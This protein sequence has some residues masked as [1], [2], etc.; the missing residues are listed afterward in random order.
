MFLL[1]KKTAEPTWDRLFGWLGCAIFLGGQSK[2]TMNRGLKDECLRYINITFKNED[3]IINNRP[4][5]G[6]WY[7]WQTFII[8]SLASQVSQE[9]GFSSKGSF[10]Q[11]TLLYFEWSPPWHAGW[12]FSGEGCHLAPEVKQSGSEFKTVWDANLLKNYALFQHQDLRLCSERDM[13]IPYLKGAARHA[14]NF[15]TKAQHTKLAM[16]K[17]ASQTS[18][19]LCPP[20]LRVLPT[21]FWHS[22]WHIFEHSFWHPFS[23]I[24]SELP[25]DMSSD[26]LSDISSDTETDQFSDTWLQVQR[27]HCC[28]RIAVDFRRGTLLSQARGWG[29]ARNTGLTGSR[30]RSGTPHCTGRLAVEVQHTTL[31]WQDRGW[32]A[33]RNT[34]LTG[35]RLRSGAPHCTGRIAVEVRH[36]TLASQDRGWGP[37]RHTALAGSRLRSGTPHWTHSIAVEVRRITLKSHGR[38]RVLRITL[39]SQEEEAEEKDARRRRRTTRRRTSADIKSNNPHLTDQSKTCFLLHHQHVQVPQ[40]GGIFTL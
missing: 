40:N 23:H 8:A 28:H 29:P 34:G 4:M 24:L 25:S 18:Y 33:A 21:S 37:A 27:R 26:I 14:Y 39:N 7:F 3:T 38:K 19:L 36:A 20:L 30:L 1:V 22:F 31:H 13:T 12:G 17:V 10:F 6:G 35:S 2:R 32:G 9:K 15:S 5:M 11:K 16:V